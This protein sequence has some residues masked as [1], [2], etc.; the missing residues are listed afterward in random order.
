VAGE[1]NLGA[2]Q[3]KTTR[4]VKKERRVHAVGVEVR[5]YLF[6]NLFSIPGLCSRFRPFLN[7][8]KVLLRLDIPPRYYII[9]Q[10]LLGGEYRVIYSLHCCFLTVLVVVPRGRGVGYTFVCSSGYHTSVYLQGRLQN[11]NL[12]QASTPRVLKTTKPSTIPKSQSPQR[13]RRDLNLKI[14]DFSATSYPYSLPAS[15]FTIPLKLR[16]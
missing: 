1:G 4:I 12:E 3:E 10:S 11:G 16:D 13:S 14:M 2:K 15:S 8:C 9:P 7:K 5:M 6:F